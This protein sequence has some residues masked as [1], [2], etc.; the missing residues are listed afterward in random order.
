MHLISGVLHIVAKY[1]VLLS[2]DAQPVGELLVQMLK[3][4]SNIISLYLV[5]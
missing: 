4:K 1:I 3:G 5:T 2:Y